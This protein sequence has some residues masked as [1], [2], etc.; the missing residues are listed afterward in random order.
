MKADQNF[1]NEQRKFSAKN[2]RYRFSG[3][4]KDQFYF[5]TETNLLHPNKRRITSTSFR[6]DKEQTGFPK[7]YTSGCPHNTAN[8][9]LNKKNFSFKKK[10]NKKGNNYFDKEKLYQNMVKLQISLNNMNMKYHKQKMEN[11]KQAREIE[12][13]NKFLNSINGQNM[14]NWDLIESRMKNE[15]NLNENTEDIDNKNDDLMKNLVRSNDNSVEL[16]FVRLDD[17]KFN[18]KSVNNNNKTFNNNQLKNL[19]EDLYQE[20]KNKEILEY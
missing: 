14:R 11:D 16:D 6:K 17:K 12:R 9:Y 10:S 8:L 4:S 1:L 13:Q 18:L 20:C 15:N 7:V 2:D 19:Y 5:P 3:L